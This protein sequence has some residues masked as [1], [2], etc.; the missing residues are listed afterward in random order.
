MTRHRQS[1]SCRG[2]PRLIASVP[3]LF[4]DDCRVWSA[5][6]HRVLPGVGPRAWG[7]PGYFYRGGRKRSGEPAHGWHPRYAEK[8]FGEGACHT[9]DNLCHTVVGALVTGVLKSC[10]NLCPGQRVD[11]FQVG[12]V[13]DLASAPAHHWRELLLRKISHPRAT[14][15][16]QW[17][18]S[19]GSVRKIPHPN[20]RHM[21]H[22]QTGRTHQQWPWKTRL[23]HMS[24]PNLT[25]RPRPLG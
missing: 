4:G 17:W 7:A 11:V 6:D 25:M 9:C 15:S 13:P 23:R 19:Q 10:D 1:S 21:S 18:R 24:H 14:R 16:R 20:L 8:T 5:T 3:G 12:I 2:E 22:R